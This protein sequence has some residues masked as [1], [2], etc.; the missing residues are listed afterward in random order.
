MT[1][2]SEHLR[3]VVR[4][5][6]INRLIA[7]PWYPMRLRSRLLSMVGHEVHPGATVAPNV[8]LGA[9]KGLHLAE[10]SYINYGCFLDLC[11]PVTMARNS[12]LSYECMIMTCTHEKGLPGSDK[13]F[14]DVKPQPVS[15]GEG[16]WIGARSVILPG[17][18]IGEFCI[19]A[20]GSV[21]TKDC[22]PNGI[23]AGVPAVR[24]GDLHES[25][26]ARPPGAVGHATRP[27]VAE[28]AARPRGHE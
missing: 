16:T 6:V 4:D 8:F 22:A 3:P 10:G 19:V 27:G 11:A 20:A 26:H 18:T 28:P 24:K 2:L 14:G 7:G 9:R 23:Y 5:I 13:T 15:I 1:R 21:V 12:A 17:V 25:G